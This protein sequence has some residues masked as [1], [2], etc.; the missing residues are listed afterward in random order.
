MRRWY[1]FGCLLVSLMLISS[2]CFAAKKTFK[3]TNGS[4]DQNIGESGGECV[5]YVRAETGID[6][7][8]CHGDA[9]Q[10]Y[11]QAADAGYA[12]GSDPRVGAI[13]VFKKV[14]S[15]ST[16]G[17]VG[18]V[19]SVSESNF[20]VRESNVVATHEI[21]ERTISKSDSAIRGYV[22]CDGISN[23]QNEYEVN[24]SAWANSGNLAWQ[25]ISSQCQDAMKWI[26]IT[27]GNI[28]ADRS[29]QS[30]YGPGLCANY[31]VYPQCRP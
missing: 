4:L 23:P 9:W 2:A 7:E 6:W 30:V 14:G 31:N 29:I 11:N 24:T 27:T 12:V 17:H 1:F 3:C 8:G 13:V 25:P 5:I 20:V 19:K 18:I 22:Y 26:D 15:Y 16:A 21:G 10:C 28:V